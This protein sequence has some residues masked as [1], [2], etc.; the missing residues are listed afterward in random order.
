MKKINP[1][2]IWFQITLLLLTVIVLRLVLAWVFGAEVADLSQYHWMADI[3]GRNENIYETPGLYHYTPIPMFFP[4]WSLR[5]A[6]ITGV[7]LS[8][9]G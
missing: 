1:L 5:F 2:P 4:F 9:C 7:T 8:F 3:I 6:A